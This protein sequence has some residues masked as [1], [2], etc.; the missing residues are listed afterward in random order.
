M[1]YATTN[2][3]LEVFSLKS[4]DSMPALKELESMVPGSES[5]ADD[6]DPRVRKMRDLVSEMNADDSVSL[7][8]DPKEDEAFLT[9]IRERVK[10]IDIVPPTI[11]AQNDEADAVKAAAKAR[12]KAIDSGELDPQAE[13]FAAAV[14][15]TEPGKT[16]DLPIDPA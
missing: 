16:A 4:L 2:D 12:A 8:Y 7:L 9:D 6:V 1:L 14:Q 13:S 10:S 15:S 3:F 5:G 11:Q